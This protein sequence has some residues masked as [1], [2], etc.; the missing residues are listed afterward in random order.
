MGTDRYSTMPFHRR[1]RR[2]HRRRST[3]G[4]HTAGQAYKLARKAYRLTDHE[5]LNQDG[6]ASGNFTVIATPAQIL[7][8][9]V[10][11]GTGSAGYQGREYFMT[12][13]L[14]SGSL[15]RDPLSADD[16]FVTCRIM[17]VYDKLP[18][19][20]AFG[21]GDLLNQ[22]SLASA[23]TY[24]QA[25]APRQI[26]TK[27]RFTV[28]YDSI[29]NLDLYH[30]GKVWKRMIRINKKTITSAGGATVAD[31]EIGSLYLLIF[32]SATVTEPIFD[33]TSRLFFQK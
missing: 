31:I 20:L 8:N 25:T 19:G 22:D 9:G 21:T 24:I 18:A 15:Y 28:L 16:H 5:K 13:L 2:R 7:M 32:S 14:V 3:A 23:S 11:R 30:P 33:F 17:L 1:K 4:R 12:S 10:G 26:D 27:K 6:L 29:F